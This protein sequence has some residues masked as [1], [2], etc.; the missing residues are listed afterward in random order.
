VV[1]HLLSS[2]GIWGDVLEDYFLLLINH[3]ATAVLGFPCVNQGV[4]GRAVARQS[5][6]AGG[7]GRGHGRGTTVVNRLEDMDMRGLRAFMDLNARQGVR[8]HE[9]G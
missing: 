8:S 6:L 5:L 3:I 9:L 2:C 7:R 1:T 4:V